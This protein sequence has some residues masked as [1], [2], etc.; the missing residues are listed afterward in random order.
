M[1]GAGLGPGRSRDAGGSTLLMLR[2][3]GLGDLL[4]GLP[5]MRALADAFP[6]HHRVLAVRSSLAPLALRSGAVD[7]VVAFDGLEDARRLP[8]CEVAVNLHG[9]GPQSHRVLLAARPQRLIAFRHPAVPQSSGAPTW[10]AAEHEVARWC[11]LLRESGIPADPARLHVPAAPRA[12][13]AV[14]RGA[15][16]LHPGA[17]DPARRWPR[18]RWIELARRLRRRGRRVVITGGPGERDLARSV[19]RSSTADGLEAITDMD[20]L[21][22]VAAVSAARAL[23][24]G[25]TG[26]GHVATAVGTPSVLLFG[27]T[28]PSLWGPPPER[29][30]HRVLWAGLHGDPH[31]ASPFE[32]L[33]RIRVEDVDAAVEGALAEPSGAYDDE[34]SAAD[35]S[36]DA[37]VAS[38][39]RR[40]RGSSSYVA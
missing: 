4:T 16:V 31:G 7:E 26:V 17:K 1:N 5:A 35:D 29:P 33:L 30:Q 15:V 27:P 14:T 37:A 22:L 9:R 20:V 23:V 12:V 25:D 24:C 28:A 21:D 10:R 39:R 2:A 6:D 8:R 19:A 36:G 18:E 3:L 38:R 13:A 11:R 40:P 32:G 34:R